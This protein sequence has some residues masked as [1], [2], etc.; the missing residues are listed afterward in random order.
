LD[1]ATHSYALSSIDVVNVASATDRAISSQG[2]YPVA[3]RPEGILVVITVYGSDQF[4]QS[5]TLELLDPTTGS[6]RQLSKSGVGWSI[7]SEGAVFG[8]DLNPADPS[9]LIMSPTEPSQSRA[10]DRAWRLDTA[11]GSSA[12]WLYRPGRLVEVAGVDSSGRL[13]AVIVG[14]D[15]TEIW[16]LNAPES[17]ERIYD[18]PGHGQADPL[19]LNGFG[20]TVP[21]I[22]DG[23]GVWLSTSTGIILYTARSGFS[24]VYT[25]QAVPAGPCVYQ[26]S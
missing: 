16:A 5:Q 14:F 9:P 24:L 22:L 2:A 1:P 26:V 12:Q 4:N 3:F 23:N 20:I 10:P 19:G 17:G 7:A 21:G 15:K 6:S 25:G 11:T 18:G 13:I 8:T